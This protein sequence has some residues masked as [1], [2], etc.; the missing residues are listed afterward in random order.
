MSRNLFNGITQ[1]SEYKI[2]LKI[3]EICEIRNLQCDLSMVVVL[4][5]GLASEASN[6]K[7]K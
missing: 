1:N 6:L 7:C 4:K 2:F 5:P 3:S